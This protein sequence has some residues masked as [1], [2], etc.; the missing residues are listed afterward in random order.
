MKNTIEWVVFGLVMTLIFSLMKLNKKKD[1]ES[2]VGNTLKL[3]LYVFFIGLIDFLLFGGFALFSN[4][5][6]NGT[7]SVATT[8]IFIGFSLLG[9]FL[10]YV[11]F[12]EKYTYD[13]NE[14]IYRKM[15]FRKIKIEWK[16][17]ESVKYSTG[18]QWFVIK[19]DDGKKAYF[20]V[21][22][23]GMKPFSEM[24]LKKVSHEKM[25]YKTLET[26]ESI[27]NGNVVGSM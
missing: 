26:L 9:L 16:S 3:P 10:V 12:V 14:I 27:M 19:R 1:L 22:L 15:T 18:M 24:I 4:L 13:E 25:N 21:M 7:E 20:A 17:V 2:N 8:A 11:Y 5:F 23:K 6:P